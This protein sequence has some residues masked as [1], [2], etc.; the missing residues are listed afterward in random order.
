[1]SSA[2]LAPMLTLYK[3]ALA[4][5]LLRQ[6]TQ[7]RRTALRLPEAEGP[8]AGRVDW[9]GTAPASASPL[10]LM[11]IGDSSAA[12]VGVDSQ[13]E[14][15]PMQTAERVAALLGRPVHWELIARSGVN[16][17]EALALF[18]AS[19]P[20][21]ADIVVSALGVNDVTSQR[22]ARRFIADY[23]ALLQAVYQRTGA[24]AT[25]ASGLPPLHVLPIAPQ[26]LRWYLGQS[27]RRLDRALQRLCA[28]R[29]DLRLVSLAWARA[30]EMARDGY[31]PGKGQYRH[32]A[33]LLAAE[34]ASLA[35][36]LPPAMHLAARD[37]TAMGTA[38]SE[39]AAN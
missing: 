3:L 26:P 13:A 31:H 29:S 22:G 21:P 36:L 35:A 32:W 5:A 24:R 25:V 6:G 16:T 20:Q 28:A 2:M 17:R 9:P 12:G 38:A 23:R 33:T 19:R 39:S 11:F 18:Q 4:P 1:M 7:L 37:T 8:R 10:R 34:V 27:A 15:M 30:D 14:A